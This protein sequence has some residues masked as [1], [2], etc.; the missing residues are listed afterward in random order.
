MKNTLAQKQNRSESG[1]DLHEADNQNVIDIYQISLFF[2]KKGA[3]LLQRNTDGELSI[4][5]GIAPWSEPPEEYACELARKMFDIRIDQF[6]YPLGFQQIAFKNSVITSYA[7]LPSMWLERSHESKLDWFYPLKA[8]T[9]MSDQARD[10][11][12]RYY[13][14]IEND[15]TF[16]RFIS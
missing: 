4:P 6:D 3:I 9:Q 15:I 1:S 5:M 14:R 13:S 16:G 10:V 7:L 11:M 8:I 12:R 2:V